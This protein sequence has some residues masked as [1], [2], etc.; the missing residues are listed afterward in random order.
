VTEDHTTPQVI[1]RDFIDQYETTD[2][3][4]WAES[5]EE[6]APELIERLRQHGFEI[7]RKV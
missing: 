2:A 3:R 1:V 4:V 5:P 6:A 7:T